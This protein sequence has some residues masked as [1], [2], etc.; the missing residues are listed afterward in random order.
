MVTLVGFST[1]QIL[2][3][4][5]IICLAGLAMG[6]IY[7]FTTI[8]L[9]DWAASKLLNV[10]NL[11]SNEYG[12]LQTEIAEISKK[13]SISPPKVGLVED[14]RPNAFILGT[15]R[16]TKL[17][18][19]VGILNALDKE[20]ILA[21]ASHELAHVKNHDFLF[22]TISNSLTVISFFNPLAYFA[23][24]NSQREREMLADENGAKLLQKP[25]SLARALTKI[26]KAL[27]NLPSEGKLIRLTSN[28]LVSS[29]IIHRPQILSGHPRI[30][31][32]LS[33][34]H[35]LT[36][37]KPKRL[38]PSKLIVAAIL[39][40]IIIVSGVSTA[41]A[42]VN[43]RSGYVTPK[44]M[45]AGTTYVKGTSA[46][47]MENHI[48]LIN[49]NKTF[50]PTLTQIY[51]VQYPNEQIKFQSGQA[52]SADQNQPKFVTSQPSFATPGT[53]LSNVTLVYALATENGTLLIIKY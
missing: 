9:G 5:G 11:D 39:T 12:W 31:L 18:F 23:F 15:G 36:T 24:F 52:L 19:T 17:V 53:N 7:A 48:I 34:I 46:D 32:R 22:K 8:T 41:Y 28:L 47:L 13:L 2:S 4:T 30:D 33:N 45:I 43:L 25:E 40:C 3:I 38:K 21:V 26:T 49:T 10:I 29:P 20:E 35:K 51:S 44:I 6:G 1:N 16:K 37:A 42:L 50:N 14:L 27:Q